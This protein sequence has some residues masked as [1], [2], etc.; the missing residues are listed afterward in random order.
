M[1]TTVPREA[2][3]TAAF[4]D[5][6]DTMVAD[7]DMVE[8]AHRVCRHCV[9]LLDVDATGMLL[10]DGRGRLGVLA[11]SNEQ[12]RLIELFQL[13]AEADGPCLTSFQTG[14]PVTAADLAKSREGW[15]GFA[16]E[17]L[18]QGYRTVH[19]LPM[20]LRD[21]TIGTLN[22]FRTN[23]IP[24]D[25]SDLALGQALADISTIAILQGR[26]LSQREIVI[27]QLQG[28]LNSRVI[29]EQAKGVLSYLGQIHVDEAFR[30]LRGY[31][32]AHNLLL[33]ELARVVT[34]D[35]DRAREVLAFADQK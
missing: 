30:I 8:L 20:R 29:I 17:A 12:A 1:S 19:A 35:R 21:E 33:A 31:A 18:R 4:I 16:A 10:A 5:I 11:S 27:E 26:A 34:D 13:Q 28:A 25:D 6:A 23:G 22:L 3:L 15:P 7:Y 32:R 24:L 9:E 2:K 14:R